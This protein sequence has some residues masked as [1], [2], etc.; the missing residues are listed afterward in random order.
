MSERPGPLRIAVVGA[1]PFPT[2]Q[3]SQVLIRQHA[4]ALTRRGHDV[5]VLAYHFGEDGVGALVP[6]VRTPP[7]PGYQ[8][9]RSGPAWGK[10]ILD[11]LLGARLRH[12]VRD[13]GI[14]VIHAH[15]YEGALVAIAVGRWARV[16][17]VYHG[18]GALEHE[19]PTYFRGAVLAAAARRLGRCFDA[20]VP[21]WASHCVAVSPALRTRL[22]SRGGVPPDRATWVPPGITFEPAHPESVAAV[23]RRL[24]L[25]RQQPVVVYTGNLDRYQRLDL[26]VAA[27]PTIFARMPTARVV[28]ATHGPVGREVAVADPRVLVLPRVSFDDVRALLGVAAVAVVPRTCPYGFPI[29]LLNALA[30]GTAT[31][32]FRSA[33]QFLSDAR[34]PALVLVDEPSPA[35]L[36]GAVGDL[37]Q[38][39]RLQAHLGARARAL[40]RERFEWSVVVE[41]L[42]RIYV[43]VTEGRCG[44]AVTR[45][46]LA[47]S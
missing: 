7:L 25:D 19:L 8:K 9:L 31:V 18:H 41:A 46:R 33:A 29:K 42:E 45:A 40:V 6:T 26:L 44:H 47:E 16:P 36:G 11:S 28:L 23:A 38:E 2:A 14:D 22:V 20:F 30:A 24:G 37:L 15:G 5:T 39:G 34:P 35:A 4:E 3:G 13:R 1:C 17:V 27:L 10:L 21:R 12:L 43:S 32:A